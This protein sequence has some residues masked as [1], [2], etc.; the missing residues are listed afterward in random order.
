MR[1]VRLGSGTGSGGVGPG[2]TV[3]VGVAVG[4]G[5]SSRLRRPSASKRAVTFRAASILTVQTGA[6]AIGAPPA[7]LPDVHPANPK[8]LDPLEDVAVSVTGVSIGKSALQ[9]CR[10]RCPAGRR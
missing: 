4:A 8:N 5:G 9:S 10:S 7:P 6:S 2:V 3:G 1:P